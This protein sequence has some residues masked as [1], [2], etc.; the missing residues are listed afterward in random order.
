MKRRAILSVYDKRDIEVLAKGL[1][2]LGYGILSTGGTASHLKK[3]DVELT[4]VSDYTGH[5]EILG[6]RVKSLHPKIHGGILARREN[7]SDM[8]ELAANGID[9]IDIVVVNLYPFFQKSKEVIDA[10]KVGH[11]SL[12]E[13]IDIGGPTMIRA[14]AKNAADVIAICDP[15]D[16]PRVL[17]ALRNG[18]D[19]ELSLIHI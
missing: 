6:G 13:S 19:L 17:E 15:D 9:P 11:E 2:D 8:K 12:V 3:H 1:Q 10:A 4:E 5:P 7:T 18:G 14:A 16:Y